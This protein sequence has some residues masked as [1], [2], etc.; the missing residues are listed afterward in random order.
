MKILTTA[1]KKAISECGIFFLKKSPSG[2]NF[3][4]IAQRQGL[5]PSPR[6][7]PFIPGLECSGTVEELGEGVTGLEVSSLL[8]FMVNSPLIQ[9]VYFVCNT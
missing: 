2:L 1:I 3:A 8:H 4:D 5:Y 7:P 9:D 6:K